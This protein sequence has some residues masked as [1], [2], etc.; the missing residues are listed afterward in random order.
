MTTASKGPDP[1]I[2]IRKVLHHLKQAEAELLAVVRMESHSKNA[3]LLEAHAF[4][5]EA[6]STLNKAAPS[7]DKR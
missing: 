3:L 5:W 4:L 1:N 7:S 2:G 6:I